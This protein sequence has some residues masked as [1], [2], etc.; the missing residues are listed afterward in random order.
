MTP[1]YIY[2]MRMDAPDSEGYYPCKIGKSKDVPSRKKQIG[3]LLPYDLELVLSVAVDDMS[4]AERV[5]HSL[6]EPY[7]LRGEWFRLPQE[8][9]DQFVLYHGDG[10]SRLL[11]G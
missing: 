11:L 3:V 8:G 1:G 10:I 6:Y 4:A 7:R 5:L 2:L 9:I